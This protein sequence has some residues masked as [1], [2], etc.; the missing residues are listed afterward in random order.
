MYPV[1]WEI[2]CCK[3]KQKSQTKCQYQLKLLKLLKLRWDASG[4]WREKSTEVVNQDD[5][6]TVA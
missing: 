3:A 2:D 4:F 5:S 6:A 1:D